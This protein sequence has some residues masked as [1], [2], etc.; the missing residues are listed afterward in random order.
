MLA[1]LNN[2]IGCYNALAAAGTYQITLAADID[3]S[4]SSTVISN[5]TTNV[6]LVIEGGGFAVDG[7]AISG[8]RPFAVAANTTVT[9]QNI[10]ITGGKPTGQGGGINSQGTL[11]LDNSTVS[12]NTTTGGNIGGGILNSGTLVVTNS[13]ISGN[14]TGSYGGGIWN[15][16]TVTVTQQH[17]QRQH[18][19]Q[20]RRR[21]HLQQQR[22]PGDDHQQHAQRQQQ[23]QQ[24]RRH[25]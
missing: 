24:R 19:D 13:T 2:A 15:A 3:L 21:R 10:T 12:G 22:S 4:A 9:M 7:Q 16:G 23:Q 6:A 5:A 17:G 11:T 20:R 1:E 18:R 25:L 8:V 14:S